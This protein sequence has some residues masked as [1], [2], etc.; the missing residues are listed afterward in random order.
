MK[1]LQ[2]NKFYLFD[3]TVSA[4]KQSKFH[5]PYGGTETLMLSLAKL[6][7]THGHKVVFFSMQ[8]PENLLSEY[9]N[10]FVPY[11][12]LSNSVRFVKQ[13]KIARRILYSWEARKR[14]AR[15][16]DRYPVDVAHLHSIHHQISPSILSEL[17]KRHIPIIMTLHDYKMICPSYNMLYRGKTCELCKGKRFYNCVKTKCH[18][19]SFSKS[20]L[21]TL[22][23]YLHHNIL[24]SYRDI[25]YF[26]CPSK[27][28]M[29][30]MQD[31][32]LKGN[33]IYLPN[34]VRIKNFKPQYDWIGNSIVY[35]GRLAEMKGLFTLVEAM[36]DIKNVFLKIIGEG[37]IKESLQSKV[38][39]EKLNNIHF[40]E[41]KVGEELK[42]EIRKSMF[43]VV[44]SE[45]Y[46][47]NPM[48]IIEAFAL[49]KPVIG[50][51]I[52]GIPEMVKD[53]ETGYLFEPG[54]PNDLSA[55][56]RY[57]LNNP[58]IIAKMGRNARTFAERELNPEKHYQK[59]MEIYKQAM[60]KKRN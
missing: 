59:L 12:D 5:Y 42:D 48:S 44:P 10:Y 19:N 45:L 53:R 22:E 24:N 50:S 43:V 34:F 14:L 21:V 4:K 8:H 1:V 23:S 18:K 35:F 11:M 51:R 13:V 2:V 29:Q 39:S 56:I 54:N 55:K 7:E 27:F 3:R 17:K 25:K 41:Y 49:G 28:I 57:L 16:L 47:N 26:V 31:M 30:K 37:P 40:I 60:A 36:K 58:D 32:G 20:L 38:K 6:L 9:S 15:L 52:G 46:E 33:F